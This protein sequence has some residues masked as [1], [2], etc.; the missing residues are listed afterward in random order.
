MGGK[1]T[2]TRGRF[3]SPTII[4]YTIL[5]FDL[6]RR[7]GQLTYR[8]VVGRLVALNVQSLCPIIERNTL[9]YAPAKGDDLLFQCA[10]LI[11]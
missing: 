8:G 11:G 4:L 1:P 10:Y 2:L 7:F 9:H 5:N 6:K 3:S